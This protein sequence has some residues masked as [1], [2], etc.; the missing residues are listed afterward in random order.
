MNDAME[1]AFTGPEGE[2]EA[3]DIYEQIC[4][5]QGIALENSALG[6]A[7]TGTGVVA[8]GAPAQPVNA[9][10]DKEMDDL[11]SRLNNL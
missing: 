10:Q 5:E 7:K 8:N 11:Q 1:D 4:A 2:Q 3:D 9:G 6:Q